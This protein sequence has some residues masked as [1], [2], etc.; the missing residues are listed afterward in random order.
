M[1]TENNSLQ[2]KTNINCGGC[3]AKV[4]PFLNDAKGIFQWEVD[5]ENKDKILTIKTDGITKEE[6]IEKVQEA[7]F[8]IESLN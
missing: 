1:K 3:I 5:T 7:G 2:F 8:K 4:T 6:I